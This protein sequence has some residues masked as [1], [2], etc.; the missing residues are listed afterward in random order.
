MTIAAAFVIFGLSV[1]TN[2]PFDLVGYPVK[3]TD[4]L[5]EYGPAGRR[6]TASST[7]TSSATTSS[8]ATGARSRSSST[9]ATTCTRSTCP[10][11]TGDC[12]AAPPV[13]GHPPDQEIDVVLWDKDLPL[14]SLLK[15]SGQWL[16]IYA[17]D[18]WVV[19]RRL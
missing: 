3:A 9:T 17:E 12:W 16:E 14:T 1:K 15:A 8:C 4:F 19:L 18:D 5:E 13:A 6:P 11:T 7:R 10:A 2:D